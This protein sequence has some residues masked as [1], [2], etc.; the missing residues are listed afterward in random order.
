MA[1]M[2]L[3]TMATFG[4]TLAHAAEKAA[5]EATNMGGDSSALAISAGLAIAI[6]AFGGALGQGKAAATALEG[7]A[8]NP[9]AASKIQTPMIIALA[10]IESLVIYALVIAFM[11]QNKI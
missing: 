7:I 10:L 5:E 4:S 11:L 2:V 6:A 9:E 3:A 8:R 1:M